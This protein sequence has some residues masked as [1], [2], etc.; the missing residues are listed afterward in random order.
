MKK[1]IKKNK[2]IRDNL[3]KLH[4]LKIYQRLNKMSFQI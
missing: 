3:R 1:K 2:N 4:T